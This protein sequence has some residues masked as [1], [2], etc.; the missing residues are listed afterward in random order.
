MI[1]I[2]LMCSYTELL[3]WFICLELTKG[4]MIPSSH[5]AV[6]SHQQLL[7]SELQEAVVGHKVVVNISLSKLW[8]RKCVFNY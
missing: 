1:G 7:Q 5:I 3:L 2:A 4:E 6:A 8:R